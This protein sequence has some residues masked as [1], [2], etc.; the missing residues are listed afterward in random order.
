MINFLSA[1]LP[2][3]G[4][5][6]LHVSNPNRHGV[7][8]WHKNYHAATLLDMEQQAI[9]LDQDP[10]QSVFYA[11]GSFRDNIHPNKVGRTQ[12]EAFMFK[13]LAFDVD[14][15]DSKQNVVY[16]TQKDMAR[17]ALEACAKIGLPEPVFVS[18]GNGLH[19]YYPLTQE[20]TKASWVHISTM[21]RDSLI[22]TGMV[23]DVSKI[24]DP[25]MVLRP[26]GTHNKKQSGVRDVKVL[27]PVTMF[28]PLDL[29]TILKAFAKPA[30]AGPGA[31][32]ARGASPI[33]DAILESDFPPSDSA[34]VE[35]NCPQVSHVVASG[36]KVGY[37][38][39]RLTL[40][41]AKHCIDGRTVAHKWSAGDPRYTAKETDEKYDGW[42]T[43]ATTCKAFERENPSQC[44]TCPHRGNITSPVQLGVPDVG[45]VVVTTA[46]VTPRAPKGYVY[47]G[48]KIFRKVS[49][50]AVF[51]SDYMLFPSNR[52][53]DEE[54]GKTICLAEC[55]LPREGWR[56]YELPMD[57][58][59]ST[60][61]FQ[62]WMI[63]QQ[64]FVHN[65]NSVDE[66]RR[67]MLT[68]LQELQQDSESDLMVGT[69]GWTDDECTSFVLGD[70]A[71]ERTVTKEV[72][73][74]RSAADFT[75]VLVPRG[76][77]TKWS[78]ASAMYNEPGMQ[79]FGLAFLMSAGSPLMVGSGLKSVL[80][81]MYSQHTG[82]GKTSTGLF[83]SSM[84]GNPAKL[85]MTV[86][87]TDNALFKSM[88]VYGNL[89][90]YIDEITKIEKDK[91]GRLSAIVYFITQ[92]REKRRMNKVGGFQES[93]EWESI[94]LASSNDDMYALLNSQMSFEGESMRI[95]QFNVPDT[96]LFKGAGS[97]F[98]YQLS[99]FLQRNYGLTGED[100]IRAVLTLGGP[101][102]V[103][104]KARARFDT[105]FGFVFT[106]GE[107]F[108]QAAFIVA[109]ATGLILNQLGITKIDIDACV[110][111]GLAE[112]RRLRRDLTDGHMDCFDVVGQYLQEHSAVTAMLKQNTTT[113]GEGRVTAPYPREAVARVEIICD[114]KT[115]FI[116]GKMFMNQVHF[117]TW[118]H[119]R[120]VDRKGV[121]TELHSHG[122]V[123]HKDRRISLMRGTDKSLPAVRVYELDMKHARFSSIMTQNDQGV[124]PLTLVPGAAD[125][126]ELS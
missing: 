25:S 124:S 35:K 36:G 61:D 103:Y 118:C 21:L 46:G 27:S 97:T 6:V 66:V 47:H 81:N 82:T 63:N 51:V 125:A 3:Q 91:A 56:T 85:M 24:C 31:S 83:A 13:T 50:E 8:Q 33:I 93:V 107:R 109:Y 92:G 16:S 70:K 123:T 5:Y 114:N 75:S 68:Y 84:Y 2:G 43:S 117:N 108:W 40:G 53:K 37:N 42:N 102:A 41:L 10:V 44:A 18:S 76:D 101:Q 62:L 105:K 121:F 111:A 22:A 15:K 60:A 34:L 98:G 96:P 55:K 80:V 19:C 28:N 29:A 9:Q 120:G 115:P 119:E 52:Y 74:S 65:K 88:G 78:E 69:F 12:A 14:P 48:D 17:A 77:R 4:N 39:W 38:L 104:A 23:L 110:E 86:Q 30:S 45:T 58:L 71:I 67:Y 116:S 54:T 20:I 126:A 89:P 106:G 95:L 79:L 57:V 99:M 73:L 59:A 113:R 90:V 64:L 26:P 100:F 32:R 94:T 122:V 11:L 7:G 72:R 49:D 112:V 87:D 1:V